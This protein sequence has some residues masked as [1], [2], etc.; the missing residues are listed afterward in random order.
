MLNQIYRT[1]SMYV[2]VGILNTFSSLAIIFFMLYFGFSDAISNFFGIVGGILQ[3]IVLNT[4]FTFRQEQ[5]KFYKS[6]YFFLILLISYLIN[7]IALTISINYFGFSSPFAQFIGI[8]CY[9]ASSFLF[10]NIFLFNE[11][12]QKED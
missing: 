5:L 12:I 9:V 4:K 11:S 1:F 3:S 10:L 2:M 8:T 7:L 6:L